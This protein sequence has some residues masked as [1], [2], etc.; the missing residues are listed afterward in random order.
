MTRM[1][2]ARGRRRPGTRTSFA[3][4]TLGRGRARRDGTGDDS[5]AAPE[6]KVGRANVQAHPARCVKTL[7]SGGTARGSRP[8]AVPASARTRTRDGR[9]R[10][11]RVPGRRVRVPG[12]GVRAPDAASASPGRLPGRG[13][14]S[15]SGTRTRRPLTRHIAVVAVM[16]S[17]TSGV[18]VLLLEIFVG[19]ASFLP[20]CCGGQ[21]LPLLRTLAGFENPRH[22]LAHA[23]P[24]LQPHRSPLS[25]SC[26][27]CCTRKRTLRSSTRNG[28]RGA[29]SPTR[30]GAA[31]HVQRDVR[32]A[33]RHRLR[34][35][36]GY[37]RDRIEVPVPG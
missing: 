32:R 1:P 24:E 23:H 2:S 3:S 27:R 33:A 8:G 18:F 10:R 22:A 5:D 34:L 29:R 13:A 28:G 12:R 4:E 6:Y 15:R 36:N 31:A 25:S 26:G 7:Y 17:F 19:L 37:P 21:A 11:V 14:S 16:A 20:A 9:G 30:A 35:P